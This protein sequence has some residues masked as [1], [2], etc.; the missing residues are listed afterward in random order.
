MHS[1][2]P[3]TK[4]LEFDDVWFIKDAHGK[5]VV[6][7]QRM[8]TETTKPEPNVTIN[9]K[10]PRPTAE[11]DAALILGAPALLAAAKAMADAI[12]TTD[13]TGLNAVLNNLRKAIRAAE[14]I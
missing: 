3:W 1:P 4:A 8:Q 9:R 2:T 7:V 14:E 13:D 6:L 5:T 11:A 12:E 10:T